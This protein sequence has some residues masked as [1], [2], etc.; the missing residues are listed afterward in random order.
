MKQA[1][2]GLE[3]LSQLRREPGR[4]RGA[5]GHGGQRLRGGATGA[6]P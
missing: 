2:K 4:W 5:G 1:A 6:D 3:L